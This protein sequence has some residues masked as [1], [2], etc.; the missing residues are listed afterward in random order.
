MI[1]LRVQSADLRSNVRLEGTVSED[2]EQQGWKKHALENHE[3][4]PDGHEHSS[5]YHG[6]PLPQNPVG[7]QPTEEGREIY[8]PSIQAVDL[9]CLLLGEQKMLDHVIYEKRPHAVIREP[10]PHFCEE[11]KVQ[12]LGMIASHGTGSVVLVLGSGFP[13]VR[14]TL[15]SLTEKWKHL[16]IVLS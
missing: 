6:P 11:K 1:G 9:R 7:E 16:K 15:E 3:K 10:L 8:K 2:Q 14:N 12:S 4:V 5:H 13:E